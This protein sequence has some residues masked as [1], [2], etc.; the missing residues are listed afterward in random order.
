MPFGIPSLCEQSIQSNGEPSYLAS[1]CAKLHPRQPHLPRSLGAW[2]AGATELRNG[3]LQ[4]SFR[5]S[6][7]EERRLP[8]RTEHSVRAGKVTPSPTPCS[9]LPHKFHPTHMPRNTIPLA[10]PALIGCWLHVGAS[11]SMGMAL[12]QSR[13]QG[14]TTSTGAVLWH[15]CNT[16]VGSTLVSTTLWL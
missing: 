9:A 15:I 12:Y 14:L 3:W 16:S 2:H 7:I 6:C 4:L 10:A 8:G 1:T 11:G 13:Q 5:A